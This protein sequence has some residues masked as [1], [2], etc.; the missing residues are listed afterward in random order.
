[1]QLVRRQRAGRCSEPATSISTLPTAWTASLWKSTPRFF[2]D[3]AQLG[4][5]LNG[6]DLIVGVHD[7]HERRV[8]AQG[9]LQL[10]GADEPVLVHIEIGDLKALLSRALIVCSTAWC[11]NFVVIR[12]FFPLWPARAPRP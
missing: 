6:A 10:G 1:M 3:G 12:C 9:G 11:S 2:A 4:D 8:L 7:A 5:G